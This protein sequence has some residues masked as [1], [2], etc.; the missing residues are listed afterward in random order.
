MGVVR[1][2]F[3]LLVLGL[4]SNAMAIGSPIEPMGV[5]EG[6]SLRTPVV[7]TDGGTRDCVTLVSVERAG[8]GHRLRMRTAS[9]AG[10]DPAGCEEETGPHGI[11][12]DWTHE[13]PEGSGDP[14]TGFF[15]EWEVPANC[16]SGY[17]HY[18][19]SLGALGPQTPLFM[20]Y[21]GVCNGHA[22]SY[23]IAGNVDF[24]L[25]AHTPTLSG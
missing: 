21:S 17:Y 16:A 3:V 6:V 13:L 15:R 5:W 23:T 4:S 19:L 24:V 12:N 14:T 11:V 22:F 10:E 2:F 20:R 9:D 1:L 8:D 7:S 18:V 25:S